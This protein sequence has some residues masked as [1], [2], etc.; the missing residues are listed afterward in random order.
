MRTNFV[1]ILLRKWGLTA[2]AEIH[3]IFLTQKFHYNFSSIAFF[4]HNRIHF[5]AVSI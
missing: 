5:N 3:A 2:G 1:H 4:W